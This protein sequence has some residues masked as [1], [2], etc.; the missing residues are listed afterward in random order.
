MGLSPGLIRFSIGL[1]HDIERT[2]PE[3]GSVHE[4]RWCLAR[5]VGLVMRCVCTRI[6]HIDMEFTRL[7]KW[8]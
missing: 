6:S 8:F 7:F 2:F 4:R 3:N 1:D 5:L